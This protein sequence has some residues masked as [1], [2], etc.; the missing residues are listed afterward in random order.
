MAVA[1]VL[2]EPSATAR[3]AQSTRMACGSDDV[4]VNSRA[5]ASIDG[6]Y[7]ALVFTNVNLVVFAR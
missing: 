1:T 4:V 6:G 5:M 3:L 7:V 2:S